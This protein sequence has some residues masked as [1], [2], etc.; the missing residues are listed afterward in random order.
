MEIDMEFLFR[1]W[2][3]ETLTPWQYLRFSTGLDQH[4]ACLLL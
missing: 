4:T 3:Q 1:T 2:Y